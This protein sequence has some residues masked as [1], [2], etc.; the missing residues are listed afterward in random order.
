MAKGAQ[1]Q[2]PKEKN[3]LKEVAQLEQAS[4]KDLNNWTTLG[5]Q[6]GLSLSQFNLN[7]PILAMQNMRLLQTF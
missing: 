1:E 4:G 3:D 2:L 6:K 5:Y 7:S